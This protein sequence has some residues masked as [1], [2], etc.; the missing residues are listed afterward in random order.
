MRLGVA[1]A[2]LAAAVA[3][4]GCGGDDTTPAAP[5]ERPFTTVSTVPSAAPAS[6]TVVA[7]ASTPDDA[8]LG[9]Y[10]AWLDGDRDVAATY[11]TPD[12]IEELFAQRPS[13][14]QFNSCSPAG[15]KYRCFFYYEGGG[16][17]MNVEGSSTA[18]F[19]VTKAFFIA[20]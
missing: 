2:C 16:L 11:A 7:G 15:S 18:G 12:P 10:N 5:E 14:I 13:E 20:D 1:S 17:N 6:P 19:L 8:A 9:L 4:V 3:L